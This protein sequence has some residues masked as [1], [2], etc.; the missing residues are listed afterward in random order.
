MAYTSS[1]YIPLVEEIQNPPG[2]PEAFELF[3][4]KPFSFYLDGGMDPRRLGRY[5]F[6]GSDPFL[7]M[8]SRGREIT[9]LSSRGEKTVWGNPF[10]VLGDL[11]RQYRL[12]ENPTALPFVG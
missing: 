10:D 1:L 9:L 4:D 12:D 7:I 8:K 11:L 6:M 3:K 2:A 5:S